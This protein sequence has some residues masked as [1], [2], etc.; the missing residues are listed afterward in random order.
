M[1]VS[2]VLGTRK[3]AVRNLWTTNAAYTTM[4]FRATMGRDCFFQ[5]LHVILFDDRTKGINADQQTN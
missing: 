4:K 3:E 5:N 1:I 2:G